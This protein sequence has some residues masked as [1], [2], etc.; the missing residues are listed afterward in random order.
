MAHV[1]ALSNQKGGVGKTTTAVNLAA[2]LAHLGM[3]VLLVDLDPQGNATSGLG[4]DVGETPMGVYDALMGFRDLAAVLQPTATPGLDLVPASADLVGAEV[5]LVDEDRREQ[6][7]RRALN[8]VRD[9]YDFIVIDCP[10]SLGLLTLNALVASDGV[11]V[12]LQ[13]EYYA[14][15]GLGALL[16]T[17][18]AVQRG[19]NPDLRR[20]GILITMSDARNRLCRDV[21]EQARQ[22]FQ[23]EVFTTVI[24][25]N[26][27]L[28]EAPSHG[29]SILDYDARSTG[30]Q[31]YAALGAELLARH[32]I[33]PRPPRPSQEAS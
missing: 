15:E 1:L 13:A 29:R 11:L 20:E 22:V 23:A 2:S 19:L 18:Q 24:P 8:P 25:R 3:R 17:V 16:R 7:L 27:R 32:G 26:V 6:R 12:P 30:A 10:P 21:E 5:E 4:H 14:M 33:T 9:E 31:A 28:G